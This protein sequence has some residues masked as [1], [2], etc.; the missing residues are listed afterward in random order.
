MRIS[1]K[2]NVRA[3]LDENNLKPIR[4]KP[5][6]LSSEPSAV[7]LTLTKDAC[8]SAGIGFAYLHRRCISESAV[9][10]HGYERRRQR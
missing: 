5:R 6:A 2:A 8:Y 10:Y 1:I 9:G 3:W 4:A 7:L